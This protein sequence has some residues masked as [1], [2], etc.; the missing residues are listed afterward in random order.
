MRLESNGGP[1]RWIRLEKSQAHHRAVLNV[2]KTVAV[3]DTIFAVVR[4]KPEKKIRLIQDSNA[5]PLFKSIF[6]QEHPV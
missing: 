6:I 5:C 4:R 2:K 1:I 3:I